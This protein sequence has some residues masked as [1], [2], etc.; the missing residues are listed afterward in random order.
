MT[1]Q[2]CGVV[3]C[4]RLAASRAALAWC[5]WGFVHPATAV[6]GFGQFL[7]F[8]SMF[9]IPAF[10]LAMWVVDWAFILRIKHMV[11]AA[12][13]DQGVPKDLVEMVTEM[14]DSVE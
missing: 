1:A 6:S 13:I 10:A 14:Q 4:R 7:I 8:V 3:G 9:P 2:G 12:A 5:W 11:G